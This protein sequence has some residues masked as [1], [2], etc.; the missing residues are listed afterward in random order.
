MHENLEVSLDTAIKVQRI[1]LIVNQSL[2]R[3]LRE[4]PELSD[5]AQTLV[6]EITNT[7]F[8]QHQKA[9]EAIHLLVERKAIFGEIGMEK[10]Q[11]YT[12]EEDADGQVEPVD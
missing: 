7:S 12:E 4:T 8:Y 10:T 5:E 3:C 9:C 6:A 2:M 11:T 1:L